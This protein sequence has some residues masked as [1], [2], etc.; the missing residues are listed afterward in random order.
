MI[1]TRYSTKPEV[2][3]RSLYLAM[4][5]QCYICEDGNFTL[6]DQQKQKEGV[7]IS[8]ERLTDDKELWTAVPENHFIMVEEDLSVRLK[9]LD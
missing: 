3:T 9:K 4:N 1:A 7:L 8:S 2:E 5:A 6:R